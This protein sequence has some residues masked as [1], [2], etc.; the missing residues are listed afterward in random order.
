MSARA[1]AGGGE[2]GALTLLLHG[3]NP[4]MVSTILAEG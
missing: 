1:N 4:A 3:T 2:S